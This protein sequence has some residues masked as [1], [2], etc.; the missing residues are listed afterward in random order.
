[1]RKGYRHLQNAAPL[2]AL[3]A[4][5]LLGLTWINGFISQSGQ[6]ADDNLSASYEKAHQRVP[7]EHARQ[8]WPSEANWRPFTS[9]DNSFGYSA[10][11]YWFRVSLSGLAPDESYY[12][13]LRAPTLSKVD[14]FRGNDGA[15]WT[16]DP[17]APDWKLGSAR[18]FDNRPVNHPDFLIPVDGAQGS[19][20]TLYFR[21]AHNGTIGFRAELDTQQQM[22]LNERPLQDF[23]SI[24]YG[25]MILAALF[26][27][28]TF[29]VLREAVYGHY[30]VL[31]VSLLLTQ[32]FLHGTAFMYLWPQTPVLNQAA[33]FLVPV[34]GFAGAWFTI[35]FLNLRQHLPAL[36]TALKVLAAT[37]LITPALALAMPPHIAAQASLLLLMLVMVAVISAGIL[38]WRQGINYARIFT[39]SWSFLI[40]GAFLV[41]LR[42]FGLLPSSFWTVTGF[43]LGSALETMALTLA[44]SARIYADR[45]AR[46]KAQAQATDEE[47]NTRRLRETLLDSALHSQT[48]G[49]P[50]RLLLERQMM[51]LH[52]RETPFLLCLFDFRKLSDSIHL[53]GHQ[54]ANS[55]VRQA[56][57]ALQTH[58]DEMPGAIPLE[59][60]RNTRDTHVATLTDTT[61][62]IL[63]ALEPGQDYSRVLDRIIQNLALPFQQKRLQLELDPRL[64]C[65]TYPDSSRDLHELL[66]MAHTAV[67][68]ARTNTT[69]MAFYQ[70]EQDQA[71]ERRLTLLGDLDRAIES[72]ELEL[73]FQPQVEVRSNRVTGVEALVRWHHPHYGYI[74]PGEFI[75]WAEETGLI[76]RLSDWAVCSAAGRIIEL[77]K[78]GFE[79]LGVA[80]NISARDLTHRPFL[81]TVERLLSYPQLSHGQLVLEV[82]ETAA[83]LEPEQALSAMRHL[84]DLGARLS[85]D[86]FGSGLSSLTYIR[87]LPL[88]EI[89]LDRELT[90]NIEQD[91][92]AL[93]IVDSVI[94]MSRELGCG[95]VVEGVEN[96][97]MLRALPQ[98]EGVCAQGFGIA[99]PMRWSRTLQWLTRQGELVLEPARR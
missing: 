22:L 89:K 21:V 1:M 82:T 78:H 80:V 95:V 69:R 41:S 36:A 11:S 91:R 60:A 87:K 38:A 37:G 32:M 72:D 63:I 52:Q 64:G 45:Q 33:L 98:D 5:L 59:G 4:A 88:T 83:M 8:N 51:Q 10:D 42:A 13:A 18:P 35:H 66:R 90:M 29:L 12:F 9:A 53:L 39:L 16:A 46:L 96:T 26:N 50:N 19:E 85:L 47:R 71:F 14:V 93:T 15:D 81:Q 67:E 24:Y 31:V 34:T 23:H 92:A 65:A 27:L 44:I 40:A 54:R 20:Q 94:R 73:H 17:T 25:L 3:A 49:L 68:I 61:H 86:D 99:H 76:H 55:L 7:P 6:L 97:A 62:A 57:R 79:D 70:A 28:A 77:R 48:T 56:C 43:A 75:P 30:L 58:A 84:R 2:L 74:S